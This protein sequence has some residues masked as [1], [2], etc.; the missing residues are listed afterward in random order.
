M[1]LVHDYGIRGHSRE[2]HA[3][4]QRIFNSSNNVQHSCCSHSLK[5]LLASYH[6]FTSLLAY[7]H[8]DKSIFCCLRNNYKLASRDMN[9]THLLPKYSDPFIWTIQDN[10]T[11]QV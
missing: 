7:Q 2:S 9:Y 3:S 5:S 10:E 1:E 6:Y 4:Q 8:A 11:I